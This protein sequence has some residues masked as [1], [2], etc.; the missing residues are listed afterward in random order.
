MPEVEI[1]GMAGVPAEDLQKH[2]EGLPVGPYKRNRL[3]EPG[4]GMLPLLAAQKAAIPE[5]EVQPQDV[6]KAPLLSSL[7]SSS[8]A[9]ISPTDDG[10]VQK[11]SETVLSAPATT[12]ASAPATTTFTSP[13]MPP[14][15]PMAPPPPA[16]YYPPQ[17]Y[18]YHYPY[19]QQPYYPYHQHYGYPQQPV[20]GYPGYPPQPYGYPPQIAP[21]PPAVSPVPATEAP[22]GEGPSPL[23]SPA[24]EVA[25]LKILP[26]MDEA[27][28]KMILGSVIVAPDLEISI[29]HLLMFLL[30]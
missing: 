15:N 29:V 11:P 5:L 13:Q 14:L 16:P 25:A 2:R 6:V 24:S 9:P 7:T 12:Y 18:G 28:G 1:Y 20:Y 10:A 22:A 19:P 4:A 30:F 3:T 21:Y 27:T 17:P 26:R 23:I 8:S